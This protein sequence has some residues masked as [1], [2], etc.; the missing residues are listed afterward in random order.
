[1][2]A[3]CITVLLSLFLGLSAQNDSAS[4]ESK[5]DDYYEQLESQ[6]KK[7]SFW[8]RSWN[9]FEVNP[10]FSKYAV[11]PSISRPLM[12]WKNV[13]QTFGLKYRNK[14]FEFGALWWKGVKAE[15]TVE[16]S[17]NR[18]YAGYF[19]PLN[20]FRLGKRYLDVKGWL[21][22]AVGGGGVVRH[23]GAYGL[24]VSPGLQ[25]QLPF[26]V[27]SARVNTEYT[28]KDGFNIVP[29]LSLQLDALRDLLNPHRVK[30]GRGSHTSTTAQPLGGGWYLVE[31][32]TSNYDVTVQ[33]VGPF[34]GI[35]PR[36]GFF[37]PNWIDTHHSSLVR[38]MGVA[39]SGR[40]NFLGADIRLDR[41]KMYMGIVPNVQALD[42]KVKNEFD[43]SRIAGTINS[44]EITFQANIN[45]V[46]LVANIIKP[47]HYQQMGWKTTPLNRLNFNLGL[48]H[49]TPGKAHLNDLNAAQFY[50]DSFFN[51]N[52]QI[53]RNAIND[54]L[55]N[56]S[57]WGVSYGLTYE[58]GAVGVGWTN[59]LTKTYGRTSF[60]EVYYILPISKIIKAYKDE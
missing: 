41:S 37:D 53:E 12:N 1:M 29:E 20:Q 10:G 7:E 27:L 2:R 45:V 19:S 40:I 47:G 56:T 23:D 58:M 59:K 15:T 5:Y 42:D 21:L 50:T 6:Y 51:A 54:P 17:A 25:L 48:T 16:K 46:G 60:I 26:T 55:Q 14:H 30:T 13:D 11:G 3:I 32:R 36:Y 57:N 49:F 24:Y 33:D 38:T 28:F 35:T 34:W 44:T 22:Q 31:S 39:L 18:I 8:Y 9:R 43:E 4:E 52:P